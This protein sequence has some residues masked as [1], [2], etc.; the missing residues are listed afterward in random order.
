MNKYSI[1]GT[2]IKNNHL[3]ENILTKH[4]RYKEIS[5]CYPLSEDVE[6]FWLMEAKQPLPFLVNS[7]GISKGYIDLIFTFEGNFCQRGERY[8]FGNKDLRFYIV[9]PLSQ[10]QT[11]SSAGAVKAIGVRIKP[12]RA[13]PYLRFPI[14]ELTDEVVA[15]ENAWYYWDYSVLERL[16]EEKTLENKISILEAWLLKQKNFTNPL[17][18]PI[19]YALEMISQSK[20]TVTV[21]ELGSTMGISFR[22]L[23]RKFLE[24]V[25]LTPKLLCKITKVR[26]A[27]DIINHQKNPSWGDIVYR[28]GFYDQSHFI[29]DFK[30]VT[31]ITPG[32]YI[33]ESSFKNVIISGMSDLSNTLSV[34]TCNLHF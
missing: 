30:S 3:P 26:Y 15:V 10:F 12:G 28:C 5:P 8:L 16:F 34:S 24:V 32:D 4:I 21:D 23:Q 31:G 18:P 25:G 7:S 17:Q 11:I 29:R 14:S 19:S 9:G 2:S 22:H 6:Y 33:N 13:F 27:I 20:G 1:N